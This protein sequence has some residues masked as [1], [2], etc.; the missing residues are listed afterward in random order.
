M[1]NMK[2]VFKKLFNLV[3]DKR[4][5]NSTSSRAEEGNLVIA[6]ESDKSRVINASAFRRLQ[7]KAQVFSLESNASVRTRLTHS[8]EVSQIGRYLAQEIIRKIPD[9]AEIS[10]EQKLAF[11]NIIETACLLHDIGNP[12]F[13]HLGEAA[14]RKWFKSKGNEANVYAEL[15]N[16]DG[17]AQGFR[18]ITYLSGGDEYGLNLTASTILSF[19]KYPFVNQKKGLFN[20][21]FRFSY[22]EA[23]EV[24]GW[25][26][27]KKFPLAILMDLA[28]EISY[29]MS[30]LEDGL[31]KGVI[32]KDDLYREFNDIGYPEP[33]EDDVY[34]YPFIK[35]KTALINDCVQEAAKQFINKLGNILAGESV[36]I[37]IEGSPQKNKLDKIKAFARKHIYSDRNVELIELAGAKIITGLL[38]SY[39]PLLS[40]SQKEFLFLIEEKK[41]T[42][43]KEDG[44]KEYFDFQLR[45]INTIPINYIRKYQT[46]IKFYDEKQDKA[47]PCEESVRAQLIVD[48]ISGMTD[49][50]ALEMYQFLEGIKIHA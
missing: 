14:I 19:V 28:D 31:E 47:N 20:A 8:I 9:S 32:S 10:Y 36:D 40:L 50:Y 4:L 35:F 45:L 49:D 17:N 37:F 30:D 46:S 11:S 22:H 1:I 42:Y 16:F 18:L 39:E 3:S 7:Q 23:C 33:R 29:C 5:R 12:P 44:G 34:P 43:T 24:L 25:R 27:G 48:F 6:S 15:V 41:P 13:G 38:N 21:D 2:E 26:E